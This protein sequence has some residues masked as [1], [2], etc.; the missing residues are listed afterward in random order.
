[1]PDTDSLVHLSNVHL[2]FGD[3]PVLNGIDI[4]VRR[5]EAVSIIGPSG[6][7]KST[8]L[9]CITGLLRPQQG[10]IRVGDVD[11]QALR[12][13]RDLIALRKRVGFVFQQYNLFPHM[14]VLE[15]LV[16]APIKV[17]GVPR[18]RALARAR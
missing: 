7:G 1:M 6:S 13:E 3:T 12:R 8:I 15:N 4:S 17:G 2:A 11:V 5:G 16:A 10:G 9:R 18:A 14:S